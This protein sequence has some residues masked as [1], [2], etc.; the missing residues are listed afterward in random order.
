MNR[1]FLDSLLKKCLLLLINHTMIDAKDGLSFFKPDKYD[2]RMAM[3]DNAY[4]KAGENINDPNNAAALEDELDEKLELQTRTLKKHLGLNNAHSIRSIKLWEEIYKY[5]IDHL[6]E[7]LKDNKFGFTFYIRYNYCLFVIPL[8]PSDYI[9]VFPAFYEKLIP[10]KIKKY[11]LVKNCL[12]AFRDFFHIVHKRSKKEVL[13]AFFVYRTISG[14]KDLEIIK[15]IPRLIRKDPLKLLKWVFDFH[16]EPLGVTKPA[17]NN[18]NINIDK[19]KEI[20]IDN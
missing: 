15:E 4:N 6:K 16:I 3:V 11:P 10:P 13:P 8:L 18:S 2:K 5:I 7:L 20:N 19:N 14:P 9:L 12:K 17:D 1:K